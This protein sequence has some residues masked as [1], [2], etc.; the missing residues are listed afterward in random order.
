MGSSHRH[1]HHHGHED[2]GQGGHETKLGFACLIIAVFMVVE[3]LGGLFANSL[4]LLADAG[5]MALDAAAL[6]LAWWAARLSRRQHDDRLTYGYHRSQVLAAF[7]NALALLLLAGWILVEAIGRLQEPQAVL[8]IPALVVATV[9]FVVNLVAFRVLHGHDNLNV[10]GAAL[11]VL[12]DLLGSVAAIASAALIWAFGWYLADPI[13]ALL[14]VAILIRGAWRV[15]RES[16]LILLEGTPQGIDLDE[17]KNTVIAQVAGVVGVHHVHA[18]ALTDEKP[19]LTLHAEVG[20]RVDSHGVV[21]NIKAV[22][23]EHFGIEHSTVQV[24]RGDCPD[25]DH[26]G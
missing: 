20:E 12:G 22:L 24:E 15:L 26:P 13:M 6:A 1:D 9:G 16:T 25:D 17:L 14:I 5:H 19:L 10:R 11:H 3:V 18:W 2:L 7:V 4:T 8:P 23:L 21:R